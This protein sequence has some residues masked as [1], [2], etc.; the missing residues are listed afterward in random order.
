MSFLKNFC[1]RLL[2]I[3]FDR[4]L[5]EIGRI[6]SLITTK[7]VHAASLTVK[8]WENVLAGIDLSLL[9]T[10]IRSLSVQTEKILPPTNQA[11]FITLASSP[12]IKVNANGHYKSCQTLR[13][14][15]L[16]SARLW[17][18]MPIRIRPHWLQSLTLC[19]LLRSCL[20]LLESIS[21]IFL[22]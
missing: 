17:L 20:V 5:V 6:I 21:Q 1:P 11:V 14:L 16:G 9:A 22:L 10:K 15:I 4:R 3:W 19:Q 18:I 8:I 7:Q 13:W 2:I 12:N